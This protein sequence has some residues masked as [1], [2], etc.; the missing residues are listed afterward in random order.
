MLVERS[1][2]SVGVSKISSNAVEECPLGVLGLLTKSARYGEEAGDVADA[3]LLCYRYCAN[4]LIQRKT[5]STLA[6]GMLIST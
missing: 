1:V 5:S 4:T 3:K 6:S 2:G